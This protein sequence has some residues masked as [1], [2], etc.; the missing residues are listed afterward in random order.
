MFSPASKPGRKVNGRLSFAG[1]FVFVLQVPLCKRH[2]TMKCHF[3]Q[4]TVQRVLLCP[5]IR[6][7]RWVLR[8]PAKNTFINIIRSK[9]RQYFERVYDVLPLP[10]ATLYRN[11]ARNVSNAGRSQHLAFAISLITTSCFT[12][13]KYL[14]VYCFAVLLNLCRSFA[15]SWLCNVQDSLVYFLSEVV[16]KLCFKAKPGK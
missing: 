3:T 4:V 13:N 8:E 5:A 14:Y 16:G 1:I 12:S 11:K 15:L 2:A 10:G 9:Y 7:A 6:R